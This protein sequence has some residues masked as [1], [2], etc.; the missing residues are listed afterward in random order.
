MSVHKEERA[1]LTVKVP[2]KL[3]DDFTRVAHKHHTTTCAL[4]AVFMRAAVKGDE[5]GL[6]DFG[7]RNPLVLQMNEYF[8]GR[9]RSSLRTILEALPEIPARLPSC[10]SLVW[11]NLPRLEAYCRRRGD[12]VGLAFCLECIDRNGEFQVDLS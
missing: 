6:V 9:P 8:L 5:T 3:R 1:W 10:P 12:V 7:A 4:I 2:R 11:V